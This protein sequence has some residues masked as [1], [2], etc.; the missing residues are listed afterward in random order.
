MHVLVHLATAIPFA[1]TGHWDAAACAVVPDLVWLPTESE[2]HKS[3]YKNWYQWSRTLQDSDLVA[4]RLVHSLLVITFVAVVF[5]LV[6]Y[7][8][9]PWFALGWL[10][11]VSLDMPT[12]AGV[13]QPRP[14]YPFPWRWPSALTLPYIRR[15]NNVSATL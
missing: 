7:W 14:L 15:K 10:T 5:E 12:H 8:K 2:F 4:Y 11:C 3:G 1:I 6:T 9:I 13:M